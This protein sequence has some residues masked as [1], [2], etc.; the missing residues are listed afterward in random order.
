MV[1]YGVHCTFTVSPARRLLFAERTDTEYRRR[2]A[3]HL[4]VDTQVGESRPVVWHIATPPYQSPSEEAS[5][6]GAQYFRLCDTLGFR[7]NETPTWCNTV[8]VL[9]L[10][11]NS[12]CFGR[13]TP[14]I[15]SSRLWCCLPHWSCRSWFAVCWRL[16]AV[17]LEWCPGWR[18]KY[19]KS[20][21]SLQPGH[22]SSLA[23]TGTCVIVAGR[24]SHHLIKV[25]TL[26]FIDNDHKSQ[27]FL[28]IADELSTYLL[29]LFISY[30]F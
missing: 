17:R 16:G 19:D 14:I 2:T 15:R 10:Q 8:Q 11:S 24:W 6:L 18:L 12:T 23:A 30:P 13:Q 7:S 5:S 25:E 22:H 4:S 28:P 1:C 3:T 26:G 27:Q 21:F 20:C 9:F 29:I